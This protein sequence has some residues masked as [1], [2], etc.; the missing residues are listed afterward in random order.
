MKLV[1]FYEVTEKDGTNAVWGGVS[2]L[3]AVEWFRKELDRRVFVSIWNEEDPEEPRL[4]TDKIE[5]S[6]LVLATILDE[7]DKA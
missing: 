6:S 4:V 7:R 3:Q 5:V 2:A 1:N